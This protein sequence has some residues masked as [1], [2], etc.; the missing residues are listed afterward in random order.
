MREL[1]GLKTTEL[2]E[3]NAFLT[4]TNAYFNNSGML[5]WMAWHT[6]FTVTPFR[7]TITSSKS[8]AHPGFLVMTRIKSKCSHIQSTRYSKFSFISQLKPKNLFNWRYIFILL[9][10]LVAINNLKPGIYSLFYLSFVE[11]RALIDFTIPYH[12][13]MFCSCQPVNLFLKKQLHF[14][15]S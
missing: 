1:K 13:A 11:L 9:G 8:G 14:V 12:N 3:F 5:L 7:K 4:Q 15:Q 10:T 6:C 2:N